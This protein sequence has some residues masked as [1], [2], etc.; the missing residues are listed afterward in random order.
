VEDEPSIQ[1]VTKTAL[2]NCNYRTLTA[3]DGIEA[4]SL[5]AEHEH[6][7]SLVLIDIMMSAMDGLMAIR[8]LQKLSLNVKVIAMSGLATNSHISQAI[9]TG[10]NSAGIESNVKAFLPK[11]YT[12]QNLMDTLQ[13]A[14]AA[15]V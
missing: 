12:T 4:I 7:A 11:P 6:D 1:Q 15:E 13:K 10:Y 9:S 14:V 3:N 2:E 8:A 5:Y